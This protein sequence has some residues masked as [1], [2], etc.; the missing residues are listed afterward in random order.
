[1]VKIVDNFSFR[2][3]YVIA[4]EL[5]VSF[6]DPFLS[7]WLFQTSDK[8]TERFSNVAD[9]YL[10]QRDVVGVGVG[11][12]TEE[13]HGEHHHRGRDQHYC[14]PRGEPHQGY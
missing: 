14:L 4:L 2:R 11:A 5:L 7:V 8:M 6:A 1:M 9:P 13:D 3:H 12:E 10:E